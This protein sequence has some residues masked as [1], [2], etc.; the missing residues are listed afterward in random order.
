MDS[1]GA[2]SNEDVAAFLAGH[3]GQPIEGLA[4]VDGGFWSTAYRYD[5][6]GDGLVFRLS[7]S[8]EGFEMD[9]AAHRFDADWLPVPEVLEVGKAL[10]RWFAISRRA[11]GRFLEDIAIEDAGVAGPMVDRLLTGLRSTNTSD[12]GA[13]DWF[14]NKAGSWH[15][16]LKRAL[17]DDPASTVSGWR[18]KIAADPQLDSLYR[19]AEA[20]ILELLE[21]CPE[22]RDLVHGDLLHQNVLV[23][24]DASQVNAVFSWKCSVLGDHLYDVAWLS[25]WEPW[26]PGIQRLDAWTRTASR[27]VE[28]DDMGNADL[29]HHC[30]ELHIGVQHL[31]WCSWTGNAASLAGVALRT[32]HV[33]ERGPRSMPELL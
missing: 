31:A 15:D 5:V 16:W 19:S 17:I 23:S 6:G 32:A 8:G 25:L 21:Y 28:G 30:Y 14:S 7:A 4:P 9:Q 1:D 13:A 26:H 27:P 10:G 3:H 11:S 29:R 24:D 18:T 2:P 20:R 12:D 22:R 33:L